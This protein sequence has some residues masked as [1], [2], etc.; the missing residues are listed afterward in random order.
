[1][2]LGVYPSGAIYP[3]CCFFNKYAVLFYSG[4]IL[5]LSLFY[6]DHLV[7]IILLNYDYLNSTTILL[8][9]CFN[10][11]YYHFVNLDFICNNNNL[12]IRLSFHFT[13]DTDEEIRDFEIYLSITSNDVILM[14]LY[15]HIFIWFFDIYIQLEPIMLR[16]DFNVRK[17]GRELIFIAKKVYSYFYHTTFLESCYVYNIVPRGLHIKKTPCIKISSTGFTDLGK[18][19]YVNF[20]W[21]Y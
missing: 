8:C 18:A 10:S 1:M 7:S 4:F 15:P 17:K 6:T 16:D 2:P 3:T 11:L 9:L 21:N 14:L 19:S 5:L 12:Y 20:N 13:Y